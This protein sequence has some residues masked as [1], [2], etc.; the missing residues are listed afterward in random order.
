[1]KTPPFFE[2]Y[3]Q[4]ED[5]KYKRNRINIK[6]KICEFI[7][8]NLEM[9]I[10]GTVTFFIS[11]KE[12]KN[13]KNL[14]RYIVKK[15]E[16]AINKI[17]KELVSNFEN[18]KPLTIKE[19]CDE[20]LKNNSFCELTYNN[21]KLADFISLVKNANEAILS[22]PYIGGE[23][24]PNL[25]KITEYNRDSKE[26]EIEV[27]TVISPPKNSN[28]AQSL[29]NTLNK[30]SKTDLFIDVSS[31][32]GAATG[33]AVLVLVA[34]A[35]ATAAAV[36]TTIF[37]KNNQMKNVLNSIDLSKDEIK[38]NGNSA[39]AIELMRLRREAISQN[40]A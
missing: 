35:V 6:S 23:L 30:E 2:G 4:L 10:P 24:D 28:H 31:F 27:L 1:M 15:D 36:T 13:I 14:H 39:S 22:V 11:K 9:F 7:P 18:R 37:V 40:F 26:S 32:C 19:S 3:R 5:E 21:K 8:E 20:V 12:N 17:G 25:L 38:K 33:V 16:K 29:L 34:T